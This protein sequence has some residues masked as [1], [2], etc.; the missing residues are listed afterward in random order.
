M[1]TRGSLLSPFIQLSA[2]PQALH[3]PEALCIK[4]CSMRL[5]NISGKENVMGPKIDKERQRCS[6]CQEEGDQDLGDLHLS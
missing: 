4:L 6:V 5:G 2:K 1:H 3:G